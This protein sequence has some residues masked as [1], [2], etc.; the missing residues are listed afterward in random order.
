MNTCAFLIFCRLKEL[1]E[2]RGHFH[3]LRYISCACKTLHH[4]RLC[5]LRSEETFSQFPIIPW[6]PISHTPFIMSYHFKNQMA[7]HNPEKQRQGQL[8]TSKASHFILTKYIP[9][10]S[11]PMNSLR[12]SRA[13][14]VGGTK[15]RGRTAR[16]GLEEAV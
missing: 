14:S 6:V 16:G 11:P 1:R 12:L 7:S 9:T 8:M 4:C 5:F 3:T 10:L 2:S 13:S 15:M